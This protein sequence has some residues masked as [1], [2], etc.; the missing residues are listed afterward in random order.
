MTVVITVLVLL[1]AAIMPSLV[2]E[3]NSREARQFFAK[4][5]NLIQETRARSMGDSQ[6]RTLRFDDSE[7]KLVV[8][9]LDIETG[10][11]V[12][13]R[14]LEL[15]AGVEGS[16]FVVEG[17]ASNS[18]EWQVGFFADGLSTEGGITLTNNGRP[19]SIVIDDRGT[20]RQIDGE[21]PDTSQDVWDAGGYEQRI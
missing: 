21:L 13:E 2:S 15:P 4:A 5:R 20:V 10:D 14:E 1:A 18:A 8:D 7:G 11:S 12:T 3:K 6:T 16:A 17:E 19:I 9:R